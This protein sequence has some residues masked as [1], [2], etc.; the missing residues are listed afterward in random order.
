MVSDRPYRKAVSR[1]TALKQIQSGAGTRF[2][3]VVVDAFT[4]V[5]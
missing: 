5:V 4:R 1:K 3:P 2:D